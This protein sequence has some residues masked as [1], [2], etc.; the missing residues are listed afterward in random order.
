M[1]DFSQFRVLI[2][3]FALMDALAVRGEPFTVR[4]HVRDYRPDGRGT[5]MLA[6][7]I[8]DAVRLPLAFGLHFR[9]GEASGFRRA[10]FHVHAS[11]EGEVTLHYNRLF[12]SVGRSGEK[13]DP[14]AESVGERRRVSAGW[15]WVD[16]PI[17]GRREMRFELRGEA[18][19]A[20]DLAVLTKS[21][22]FSPAALDAADLLREASRRAPRDEFADRLFERD[23]LMPL[24]DYV[25]AVAAHLGATPRNPVAL[26]DEN[27]ALLHEGQPYFPLMVFH[28]TFSPDEQVFNDLPVN[29]F[30]DRIPAGESRYRQ[31]L[32]SNA[33]AGRDFSYDEFAR[34]S[35]EQQSDWVIRHTGVLYL[36]D[37][38]DGTYDPIALHRLHLLVKCF[39]PE[40]PTACCFCTFA[41]RPEIYRACDCVS[42]DHYPIGMRDPWYSVE[43]I[44]WMV[45]R[46]RWATPDKPVFATIQAFDQNDPGHYEGGNVNPAEGF[47]T[48]R[49]L[50]AM[51][52]LA[53]AHGARGLYFY[54]W[55]GLHNGHFETMPRLHPEGYAAFRRLLFRLHGIERCLIG[56]DVRLPWTARGEAKVR[57][58]TAADRSEA[59]LL[60][61]NPKLHDVVETLT[62]AQDGF[63]D[64]RLD[65]VFGFGVGFTTGRDGVTLRMEELGSVLFRISGAHLERLVRMGPEELERELATRAQ[66]ES[67]SFTRE[68]TE[69]GRR[70]Q[71]R[72]PRP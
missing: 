61:V 40:I 56:P 51:S 16:F 52:W 21:E 9:K 14:V 54:N 63:R 44:G 71:V 7:G 17:S 1:R 11:G 27:G 55:K 66:M 8:D 49:E 30:P 28:S 13:Q 41:N 22:T 20:C 60:A 3:A 32:H 23:P 48:E 72:K 19:S 69:K 34:V 38:P 15:N 36:F 58:L 42:F 25:V 57:V 67:K 26:T 46:M 62:P 70:G 35:R 43:A 10:V 65:R 68:A 47:P 45:D 24:A 33:L 4:I 2:S 50:N 64:V 5:E 59:Y 29:L 31:L 53:V 12:E 39:V 18:G 37:E 6:G